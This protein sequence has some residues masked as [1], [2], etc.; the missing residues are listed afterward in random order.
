MFQLDGEDGLL[1]RVRV[2]LLPK[3]VVSGGWR[4]WEVCGEGRPGDGL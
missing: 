1:E 4:E 2:L 3:M